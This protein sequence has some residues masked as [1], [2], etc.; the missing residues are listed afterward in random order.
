M[1]QYFELITQKEYQYLK[2]KNF[3]LQYQHPNQYKKHHYNLIV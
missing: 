3:V 1:Y 2:V